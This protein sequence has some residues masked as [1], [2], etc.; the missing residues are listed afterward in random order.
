[1]PGSEKVYSMW[2]TSVL[3][4]NT[5]LTQRSTWRMRHRIRL[6]PSPLL[7]SV[8]LLLA[9]THVLFLNTGINEKTYME[10]ESHLLSKASH[11]PCDKLF[12]CTILLYEVPLFESN[13]PP[14]QCPYHEVFMSGIFSIIFQQPNQGS[15]IIINPNT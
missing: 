3:T 4:I 5:Y 11:E 8:F 7:E 6:T 2:I 15:I 14:T 10:M 12:T 1:M 13:E 9:P